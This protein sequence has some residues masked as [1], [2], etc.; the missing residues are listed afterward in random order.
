MFKK[1]R[2]QSNTLVNKHI[3]NINVQYFIKKISSVKGALYSLTSFLANKYLLI[4]F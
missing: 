1:S 3:K 4:K 2:V